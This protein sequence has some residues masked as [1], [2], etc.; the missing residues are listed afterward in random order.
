MSMSEIKKAE[1]FSHHIEASLQDGLLTEKELDVLLEWAHDDGLSVEEAEHLIFTTALSQGAV[2]EPFEVRRLRELVEI[3][4]PDSVLGTSSQ[5]LLRRL[6]EEHYKN[7]KLASPQAHID[8]L[9]ARC[10]TEAKVWEEESLK[11]RIGQRLQAAG[12]DHRISQDTWRQIYQDMRREIGTGTGE[13]SDLKA[14][15]FDCRHELKIDIAEPPPPVPVTPPPPA[16]VKKTAPAPPKEPVP[17]SPGALSSFIRL[18][19]ISLIVAVLV[20]FALMLWNRSTSPSGTGSVSIEVPLCDGACAAELQ[21][22]IIALQQVTR[23]ID[24]KVGPMLEQVWMTCNP[25]RSLPNQ[26]LKDEAVRRYHGW[27]YCND[28]VIARLYE[29]RAGQ[30]GD[31]NELVHCLSFTRKNI[32]QAAQAQKKCST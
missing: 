8:M 25:Y 13:I 6:T 16:A 31:C 22:R 23:P 4:A 2:I 15:F 11:K 18:I 17:S 7:T 10:L 32:C 27:K 12:S 21:T 19:L 24:A 28:A 5:A 29:E 14:I 9:L 3:A 20:F 30:V 26:Q 1:S